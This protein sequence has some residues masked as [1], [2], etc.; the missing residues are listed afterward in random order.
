[1]GVKVC[2]CVHEFTCVCYVYVCVFVLCRYVRVLCVCVCAYVVYITIIICTEGIFS[3][4][5]LEWNVAVRCDC[6]QT[7]LAALVPSAWRE[8]GHA[9]PMC[10]KTLNSGEKGQVWGTL[11]AQK[12]SCLLSCDQSNGHWR[13]L[14]TFSNGL[15]LFFSTE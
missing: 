1:M 13:S 10:V 12:A 14:H 2:L 3:S 4:L 8:G 11:S 5:Q 9:M 6:A 7:N 15:R